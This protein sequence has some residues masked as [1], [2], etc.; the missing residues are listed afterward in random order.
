MNDRGVPRWQRRR[1]AWEPECSPIIANA[2]V[3]AQV[4]LPGIILSIDGTTR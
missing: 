3:R 2:P 1:T 4:D